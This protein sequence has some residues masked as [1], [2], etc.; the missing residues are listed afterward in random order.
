MMKL[1][2]R[3]EW[4]WCLCTL[5]TFYDMYTSLS[6]FFALLGFEGS[7]AYY[8]H[9]IHIKPHIM[10]NEFRHFILVHDTPPS[11]Q[12]LRR[13]HNIGVPPPQLEYPDSK[14][15]HAST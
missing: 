1:G 10:R 13:A 5:L 15:L 14:M 2:G 8:S 6:H 11:L 7:C 9:T 12:K 3:N 4:A